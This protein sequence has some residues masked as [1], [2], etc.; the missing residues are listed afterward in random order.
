M[1]PREPVVVQALGR[2]VRQPR[3][4]FERR[5]LVQ[6][7]DSFL[8]DTRLVADLPTLPI[9]VCNSHISSRLLIAG[10]EST[11][12]S[13]ETFEIVPGLNALVF[14]NA[15]MNFAMRALSLREEGSRFESIHVSC[16]QQLVEAIV[17]HDIILVLALTESP[18]LEPHWKQHE[19]PNF[20]PQTFGQLSFHARRALQ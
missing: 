14:D 17:L 15:T 7:V 18:W 8:K 19:L 20:W 1:K 9:R 5:V 11:F 2:G 3:E 12:S 13:V 6:F 16:L 10:V 4:R